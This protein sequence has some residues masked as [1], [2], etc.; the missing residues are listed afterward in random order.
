M[1]TG[2]VDVYILCKINVLQHK[3]NKK[4]AF[5]VR[6]S[7]CVLLPCHHLGSFLRRIQVCC[8]WM[9]SSLKSKL[10][11]ILQVASLPWLR[12]MC[13]CNRWCGLRLPTQLYPDGFFNYM[14]YSFWSSTKQRHSLAVQMISQG[15]MPCEMPWQLTQ[16]IN[17]N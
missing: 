13:L 1:N 4:A 5:W 3:V 6:S 14:A 15:N 9:R 10:N 16:C 17:K 11:T 2:V 8:S 12:S 7:R